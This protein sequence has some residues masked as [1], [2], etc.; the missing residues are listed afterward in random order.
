VTIRNIS[1]LKITGAIL[2]GLMLTCSFPKFNL[3]YLAW[4]ALIPLLMAIRDMSVKKSF[5][6]G[7]LSGFVHFLTLIYWIVNTIKTYGHVPLFL[8]LPILVLLCSYLALYIGGFSAA[9]SGFSRKRAMLMLTIP[10]LWVCLEYIRTYFMSGFPWGLLGYSQSSQLSVIQISD[11]FGVFGVS[12]LILMSN[13]AF[14]LLLLY[15][16]KKPWHGQSVSGKIAGLSVFVFIFFFCAAWFYG[17]YQISFFDRLISESP[18][19]RAAVIQGNIDQDKKWDPPFQQST[20]QKYIKLSKTAAKQKPDI[21]IWPETATP[22]YYQNNI[23]LTKLIKKTIQETRTDFLI[24]TP[25]FRVNGNTVN[26]FNS[27]YLINAHGKISDKY[28]KVHLV[29]FGEYVP[30]QKWF[31]FIRKIT[32]HSGDFSSGYKGNTLALHEHRLGVQICFEIIFPNLSRAMAQNN[33][34]ILITLTN[35]AWFG[36]SASP[37]Q[38]FS[39]T[40]FRAVENKRSLVRSANT[41]ISGFIDP[42]GRVI[43]ETPLFQDITITRNL[44][45]IKNKTIYTQYGDFF[46][47]ACLALTL[48]GIGCRISGIGTGQ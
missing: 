37:F 47:I 41:G 42:L 29:P 7:F 40:V 8:C 31:P 32:A 18:C 23:T 3:P 11:I 2:T 4:F 13:A 34:D 14:F 20:I 1:N 43:R 39:M 22:F 30:F 12:F 45:I 38:H 10:V 26:Y 36:R 5:R 28:D 48:I 15:I 16:L 33:A 6:L 35:D 17:K 21:I 44:P 24:G 27:A 19:L 9:L 25:S 46:A